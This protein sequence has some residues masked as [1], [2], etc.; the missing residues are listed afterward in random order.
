VQK[1]RHNYIDKALAMKKL[2]SHDSI[3]ALSI[4]SSLVSKFGFKLI[5]HENINIE[6][7]RISTNF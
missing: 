4:S 3:V 5:I 7:Y 1:H 6:F 2:A